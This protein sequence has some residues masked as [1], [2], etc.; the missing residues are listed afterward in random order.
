MAIDLSLLRQEIENDPINLGYSSFLAIRNDFTIAS[1]L[2][3]VR[4]D[5]DHVVSRGRI[6]KD[7]FLDITAP[8][9]FKIMQL[10]HL[11]DSQAAFWL[12]VFD[13]LVANS[14]NINTEDPNFI[15]LLDQMMDDS[16]LTQQDKDLIISRQGTRSEKLFGFLVKVDEVSESLNE[17][18]A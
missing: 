3:E 7:L 8:I 17:G 6:S 12:S 14:D 11:G 10:A 18:G 2:N 13:R 16:V 9:V 1:M 5:S 4:Q 15:T